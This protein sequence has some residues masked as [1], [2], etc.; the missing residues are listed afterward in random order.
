[1]KT[2][3]GRRT[4]DDARMLA[5]LERVRKVLT[6]EQLEQWSELLLQTYDAAV[7]RGCEQSLTIILNDKGYPRWMNGS[8]NVRVVK[9]KVYH[10]E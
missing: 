2:D 3:D 1:M 5:A 6:L 7:I 10:A 8:N 4:T 9:P